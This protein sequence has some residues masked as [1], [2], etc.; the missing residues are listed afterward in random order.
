MLTL[1][2]VVEATRLA[3]K[4]ACERRLIEGVTNDVAEQEFFEKL[5]LHLNEALELSAN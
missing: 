4:H 1:E 5:T 2:Q 3:T